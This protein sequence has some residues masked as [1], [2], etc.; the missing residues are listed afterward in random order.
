MERL[1]EGHTSFLRTGKET[2]FEEGQQL[3]QGPHVLATE[4]GPLHFAP[5]QGRGTG[6]LWGSGK[7]QLT[8]AS[9][10][11]AGRKTST[12]GDRDPDGG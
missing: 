3:T 10:G 6:L 9:E 11:E 2:E 1:G 8:Q 5:P 7:K 4:A 12:D